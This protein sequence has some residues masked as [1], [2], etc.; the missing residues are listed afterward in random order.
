MESCI[1]TNIARLRKQKGLTQEALA[2]KLNI[3][4]Q[5]ISKWENAQ[6]RPD[7]TLLPALADALD[8]N[9]DFLL[10][11]H[12]KQFTMYEEYY[13]SD[14]YYWGIVPDPMCYDVLRLRPPLKPLRLLDVGCGE[15]RDA[16][17]FAKNG[18]HVSAFDIAKAGLEKANRLAD[19]HQVYVDFFAANLK[20]FRLEQNFDVIFST[21][22]VFNYMAPEIRKELLLDYQEHT[23]PDGIHAINVFIKKPFIAIAPDMEDTEY[24]WRSGELFSRY[25]DWRFCRCDETVYDC[26]SS[27]VPH[28]HCMDT[29]I[30]QKYTAKT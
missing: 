3:S 16:V 26:E 15:G 6:A 21:N 12:K 10:G 24:F 4:F 20:D 29:L 28:R 1:A 14:E 8:T 13:Q 9:I 22:G 17:F 23:A 11:Y 19:A 30:A 5:S 7:L 27:G 2:N 18:Y 25:A